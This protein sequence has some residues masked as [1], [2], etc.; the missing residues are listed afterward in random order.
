MSLLEDEGT[1]AEEGRADVRVA[2]PSCS[3]KGFCLLGQ[4]KC[5]L[6]DWRAQYASKSKHLISWSC[7][8]KLDAYRIRC[9]GA[10]F[11]NSGRKP[12]ISNHSF[13]L[14]KTQ[15]FQAQGLNNGRNI[16]QKH[17]TRYDTCPTYSGISFAQ[18]KQIISCK[19]VV[20]KHN[21]KI[22]LEIMIC[23]YKLI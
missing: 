5:C 12:C 1:A 19:G 21:S 4:G 17:P 14:L 8:Q 7:N 20:H 11:P 6:D 10:N 22:L 16:D 2:L 18:R 23:Q 9:L 3:L 15:G 13:K